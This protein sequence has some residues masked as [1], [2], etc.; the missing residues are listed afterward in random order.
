MIPQIFSAVVDSSAEY[1]L[2]N[3]TVNYFMMIA[4]DTVYFVRND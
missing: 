2:Y 1:R 3:I 4:Y